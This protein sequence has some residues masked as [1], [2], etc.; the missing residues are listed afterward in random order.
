VCRPL[1][2]RLPLRPP[3]RRLRT[4][5]RPSIRWWP[6]GHRQGLPAAGPLQARPARPVEAPGKPQPVGV[7]ADPATRPTRVGATV[8]QLQGEALL[9]LAR[10]HQHRGLQA[11]PPVVDGHHLG[12]TDRPLFR[13][14]A[15]K[16]GE[17]SAGRIRAAWGRGEVGPPAPSPATLL[18]GRHPAG[19]PAVLPMPCP[20]GESSTPPTAAPVCSLV[21]ALAVAAGNEESDGEGQSGGDGPSRHGD[22]FGGYRLEARPRGCAGAPLGHRWAPH[23]VP[24]TASL[25]DMVFCRK[26]SVL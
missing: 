22:L 25:R 18:R 26:W 21:G 4:R 24:W 12:Q 14:L 20:T 5:S 19:L 17:A 10:G 9:G 6:L 15:S 13:R 2:G 1:A 8:A 3:A 16:L 23:G 7:V 11:S